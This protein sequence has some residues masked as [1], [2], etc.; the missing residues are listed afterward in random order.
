MK[1]LCLTSTKVTLKHSKLL[2]FRKSKKLYLSKVSI[3]LLFMIVFNLAMQS[4]KA[5][6]Q[7]TFYVS[8]LG[9]DTNA[10]TIDAPFATIGRAQ[11]AVV[12]INS[13]MTGDIVVYLRGGNYVINQG[14]NL[15]NADSGTNGHYVRY[16]NYP[17]EKPVLSCG[18]QVT[19][20]TLDA[21]KIYK[22]NVGTGVDFR[23][24]YV[25]GRREV[26]AR[27]PNAGYKNIVSMAYDGFNIDKGLLSG[28]TNLQNV[29]MAINL[30]WMHK[31]ARIISTKDSANY[32]RAT[33]NPTEWYAIK[34]QPQ[35][36]TDYTNKAFWLENA[37]EFLDAEGE[38]Y[39]N[40]STGIVYYWPRSGEDINTSQIIIPTVETL[41]NLSGTF[42]L[43]A[44]NIEISGLEIRYTNWTR[45]NNYGFIDVQANSLIPSN[46]AT[47]VNAQYRHNQKKDRVPAAINAVSVSNVRVLNNRF[48]SLGGTGLT[49]DMGGSHNSAIG[50]VFCDISGGAI[51]VGNDAFAPT[52][53]RM[54]P[55]SDTIT[56]NYITHIGQEYYGACAIMAYYTDSIQISH[57]EISHLSYGGISFGWGW[58][59]G[60]TITPH[61]PTNGKINYN[62]IDFASEK[63]FDTG[64]IYTN[65]AGNLSEIAYNYITNTVN[66]VGVF[67][68]ENTYNFKIHDNILESNSTYG[69]GVGYI[70]M[71]GT[72][73]NVT[74]TN[75]SS[76][77]FTPSNKTTIIAS[78]GLE[79]PYKTQ[80][81]NNL[82]EIVPVPLPNSTDGGIYYLYE[83]GYLESGNWYQSSLTGYN[84]TASRYSQN[85]GASVKWNPN[86][87]SGTYKVSVFN[88]GS[89][90]DPN[91]K[92]IIA[93]N[94]I[95][96]T[97]TTNFL[98]S[99]LNN[100][101]DLG[102]YN[103]SAGNNGYVSFTLMTTGYNGRANAIK[104]EKQATDIGSILIPPNL[105]IYPNPVADFLYLNL[106]SAVNKAT[107]ISITSIE[108]RVLKTQLVSTGLNVMDM[109]EFPSGLY[110]CSINNNST[111][112]TVKIVKQ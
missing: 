22:A 38:W 109:S 46:L 61:K 87:N 71:N 10:G 92:V 73:T 29:E 60:N 34:T 36:S 37:K 11:Q 15:G 110:F 101:Y 20:W 33:I 59:D 18:T 78:A 8:P 5:A 97:K 49:F 9:N 23:Q 105:T 44:H 50:N 95:T 85:P 27:T 31:K 106:K 56:N 69:G 3:I 81:Y 35:G 64:G 14:I 107:T 84:G 62:R 76:S 102:T 108:G 1:K 2:S 32:T 88:I 75:N 17:G 90:S 28:I 68:D 24:L 26:R 51:E 55:V 12:V 93:H 63:L 77:K 54:R 89:N 41:F 72:Q 66:D 19:G 98:N 47:A 13:S 7:A 48:I 100:W 91:T 86:L 103:F 42:D 83:G 39:F 79:E 45:P 6:V 74:Y 80:I 57:N 112:E 43:P 104:F 25:N 111:I 96:E 52:D 82:P 21:G 30:L 4:A 65:N 40:K 94:G 67:N 58:S 16:T 99:S 53:S 70:R